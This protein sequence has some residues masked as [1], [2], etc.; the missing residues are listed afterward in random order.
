MT[1]PRFV[2]KPSGTVENTKKL[3]EKNLKM[4]LDGTFGAILGRFALKSLLS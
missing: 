4:F 2:T 3:Y 1:Y